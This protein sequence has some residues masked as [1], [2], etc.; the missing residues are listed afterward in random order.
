MM[1]FAILARRDSADD[2]AQRVSLRSNSAFAKLPDLL[3]KS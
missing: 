1:A 2:K 3:R